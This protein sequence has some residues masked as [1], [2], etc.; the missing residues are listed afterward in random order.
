MASG[1]HSLWFILGALVAISLFAT[2][3]SLLMQR[4]FGSHTALIAAG[5]LL[6][7][8]GVLILAFSSKAGTG[9]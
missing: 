4:M 9:K 3:A 7:V 1:R 2:V 5:P 8:L 6:A